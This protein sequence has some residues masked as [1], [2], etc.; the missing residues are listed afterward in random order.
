MLALA[1]HFRVGCAKVV[2]FN[3][4]L[5]ALELGALGLVGLGID[6]LR[7]VVASDPQ[8]VV[9]PRWPLGLRPPSAWDSHPMRVVLAI[10]LAI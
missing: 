3:V 6:Y 7:K 2:A 9:G 10:A 4:A 1:W 5:L 8:K